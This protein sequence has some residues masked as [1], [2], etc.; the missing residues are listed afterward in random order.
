[1]AHQPEEMPPGLPTWA[2]SIHNLLHVLT[3]AADTARA[4]DTTE[5]VAALVLAESGLDVLGRGLPLSAVE[6]KV[7]KVTIAFVEA[8]RSLR[9][10]MEADLERMNAERLGM[11]IADDVVSAM[12]EELEGFANGEEQA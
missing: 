6:L 10:E 5:I 7:L 12:L 1:M 9:P 3:E 8:V 2:L 11:P 4:Q